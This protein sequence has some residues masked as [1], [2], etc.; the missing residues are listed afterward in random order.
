[1]KRVSFAMSNP[2]P[3]SGF[4]IHA[5][6]DVLRKQIV[7]CVDFFVVVVGLFYLLVRKQ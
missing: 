2:P 5:M 1:M 3:I 7:T 6:A 4:I